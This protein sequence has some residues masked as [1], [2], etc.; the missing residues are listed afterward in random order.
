MDEVDALS[1]GWFCPTNGDTTAFGDPSQ[2]IP[3]SHE[4]FLKV[5]QAA[6]Q[7]GF[8]YILV[9]VTNSCWDAWVVATFI[10]SRTTRIKPLVAMKPG[11]IHPVAQAKM[12]A[13][14]GQMFEGRICI[15][16]IAG[17][18]EKEAHAEGQRVSKVERYEQLD[19]EITLIRRLL[20]EKAVEHAGTYYQVHAPTIVPKSW[21]PSHPP[22]Y[23]GGGSE[24]AADISARHSDV[25]LFWGDYPAR[26][27]EQV[28]DMRR[29]AAQHGRAGQ[30][31][32]AMR[33]QVI[34]RETEDAAWAAAA[35]LVEGADEARTRRVERTTNSVA[36]QRMRELSHA[37][38]SRLTPHLW[39]GITE[40]RAGA[41]VAV[42]G[43]PQQVADQ[44]WEFVEAGCSGF[45]LSGY[46]HDE[47]ATIFGRL[48]RPL[49]D[50]R[51]I[52]NP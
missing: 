24:Q 1:Y 14:F 31:R 49:L 52:P 9:P 37:A 17:L 42:V 18:S 35:R 22:I 30:L 13:T 44:L 25:H 20:S 47:E 48:V 11:F 15:N 33:L 43:N 38:G 36:D 2:S 8:E 10:A 39:T 51:R 26:I 12:L 40:V 32:F 45:C 21:W 7:A 34:C 29:R 41:G 50:G 3:Q 19:E 23:L 27:A 28:V 46:P 16:L 4:H 5:A 6:E